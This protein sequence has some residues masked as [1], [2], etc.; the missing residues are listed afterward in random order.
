MS[1]AVWTDAQPLDSVAE[2]A[3]RAAV[4]F[5]FLV[6]VIGQLLFAGYVAASYGG[7]AVRGDFAAWN[8][9]MPLAHVPGQTMGNFAVA[10]HLL[11]GVMVIIGGALQLLP[12]IR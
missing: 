8:R 10:M 4:R 12:H 5:W 7:P 1:T 2:A 6:T 11:L 3:L 9:H